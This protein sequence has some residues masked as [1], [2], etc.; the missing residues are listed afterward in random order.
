MTDKT[1][2][3]GKELEVKIKWRIPEVSEVSDL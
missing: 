3:S 1:Q 2:G